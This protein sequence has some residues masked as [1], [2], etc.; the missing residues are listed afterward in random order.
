MIGHGAALNDVHG[1]VLE[2]KLMGFNL[3]YTLCNY[4]L[5]I[6]EIMQGFLIHPSFIALVGANYIMNASMYSWKTCTYEHA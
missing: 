5:V 3:M 6:A 1:A 4:H 2:R